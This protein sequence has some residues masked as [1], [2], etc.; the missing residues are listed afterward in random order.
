MNF[1]GGDAVALDQGNG[2]P[3]LFHILGHQGRGR[4]GTPTDHR[5]GRSAPELGELGGHVCVFFAK[6]LLG[7]HLDAV[8]GSLGQELFLAC[9]PEEPVDTV[10]MATCLRLC[11]CKYW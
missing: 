9:H 6:D 11:F 10:R 2:D 1:F 8:L 3:Q 7:H 5:P 4:A